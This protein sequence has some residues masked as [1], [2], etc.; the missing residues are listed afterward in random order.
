M[1]GLAHYL[2]TAVI[3][4]VY[5]V[6]VCPFIESLTPWQVTI[7][8]VVVLSVQYGLR[9]W[10]TRVLIETARLKRRVA[11][12]IWLEGGLFLAAA[13]VL[14]TY[15]RLV[16]DFPLDS[17]LKV[18]VGFAA[19][20][21]LA[22]VDLALEQE[23]IVAEL[24]STRGKDLSLDENFLP[25]RLKVDILASS[26]LVML[27]AIFMLLANKDLD[28]MVNVG[29]TVSLEDA[30]VSVLK[31]F[32]FVLAVILPHMLNIIHSYARN[33]NRALAAQNAVLAEVAAGNYTRHVP[34][35]S[36][37]EY[38][39]MARGTNVMVDRIR[40][41]TDELD[42]TRDATIRSLASLAETRDNETGAHIQRTQ[43]YVRTLAESL[44]D[45]P[46]FSESLTDEF[47]DLL[48][49]SAPLHDIGKV[50]IPDAI[51]L[52][53]G[54]LTEDEFEIMKTHA[55]LGADALAVAEKEL[56][57]N[58][59]LR[60]SREIAVTHHEKWDGSGYPRG[61]KG[62]QI[63]VSGRLMAIAD[64]YDALISARVYKP[65]FSHEKAIGIIEK[66]R[67]RHFD[68]D[69]V[70]ALRKRETEFQE[71]ARTY[72]DSPIDTDLPQAS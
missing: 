63:P 15:N 62:D 28:W 11:R 48:F 3:M 39:L 45:H 57:E 65:A 35:V 22:A 64:V 21:F 5:G 25:A 52:K 4:P 24:V 70:D 1:R 12:S 26:S 55:Q 67:G 23:R 18:L 56:G 59:F 6:Q 69:M 37:D 16:Y 8:I 10:L 49:K 29:T 61:L 19:L 58:S 34:V 20:G 54:K 46:R 44:R 9:G 33:L 66:G 51:L 47:I 53:P 2:A 71:I 50:G 14:M 42:R 17:G 72:A 30:R 38:G 27:V 13:V 36:N 7:P 68:P 40:E 41:H 31:E 43:R 60:L 32:V